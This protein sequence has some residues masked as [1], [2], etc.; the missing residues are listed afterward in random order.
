MSAT[1]SHI[2]ITFPIKSPADAKAVADELPP[3][4]PD[5]AK[6]QDAIGTIHYSRFLA[7]D[8]ETLLF[9][10]DIDGDVETLS[11]ALVKSAGPV[12]RHYLQ[13]RGEPS[14]TASGQ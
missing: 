1:Q 9:L 12:F 7:L 11:G 2:T 5:F 14:S 13:A 8:D 4:M 10:A 3:L 6:A